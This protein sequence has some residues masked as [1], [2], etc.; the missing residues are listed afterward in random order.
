MWI[1]G[2]IFGVKQAVVTAYAPT[3][4]EKNRAGSEMFY[5]KMSTEI[6][7]IRDKYENK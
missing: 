6:K 2:N 3:N 4:D 7:S 5:E 1:V